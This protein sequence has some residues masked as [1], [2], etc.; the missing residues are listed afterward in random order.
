MLPV[1]GLW[2]HALAALLFG[3]LA[4]WQLR[5]WNGDHRNRPLVAAFAVTS[6][7]AIF[8]ALLGPGHL[9][10]GLAESARNFALDR[11]SVVSG[12]SVSVR[13]DFGGRRL[14][15]KKKTTKTQKYI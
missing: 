1:I 14:I 4:A 6:L 11:K 7:W 12:K 8:A 15:K 13:V 9:L 10:A 5:H 2:S 3:A